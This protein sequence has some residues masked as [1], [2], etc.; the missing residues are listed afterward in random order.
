MG[1]FNTEIIKKQVIALLNLSV[2]DSSTNVAEYSTLLGDS[3]YSSE[4]IDRAIISA[5]NRIVLAICETDGHAQR[6]AFQIPTPLA[7]G[8]KIPDHHGSVGIP[9]ITP[10]N[11]AE[12]K[13]T[14]KRKS[15]EEISAYRHNPGSLYSAIAH[16][17]T[18][19]IFPSKLAGFYAIDGQTIYFTGYEA[20]S[21]LCIVTE[22][23]Y[24][25]LADIY[26]D[27]GI[28]LSIAGL[29]KDGDLS[30]IFDY[31]AIEGDK[32][33]LSIKSNGKYQPSL[34][35]TIGK[36]DAGDK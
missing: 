7:H 4:E 25:L 32:G 28:C 26:H 12:Y 8:E 3:S 18:D 5:G 14:G 31:Y 24:G 33:I 29:R 34:K 17:Q 19:G 9:R 2:R 15:V 21:D 6:G 11:G 27:L 13:I 20:E 36:R 22:D 30:N 10:F 35:P 16:D 23:S 1:F